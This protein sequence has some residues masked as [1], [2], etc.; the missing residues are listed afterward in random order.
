MSTPNRTPLLGGRPQ[1]TGLGGGMRGPGLAPLPPKKEGRSRWVFWLVLLPL[2]LLGLTYLAGRTVEPV[3]QRL[4]EIP[5]A[6]RLLFGEPVWP[7]LWNKPAAQPVATTPA[8][9]AQSPG[10]TPVVDKLAEEAAKRLAEADLK[11]QEI[12][13][14]EEAVASKEA[15]LKAEEARLAAA[16]QEV[17]DLQ[18]QLQGQLRMEQDRV[19]IVRAMSRTAQV[20]FFTTLTDA[21][22]VT[23]LKYMTTDEVAKILGS[24]DPYRAGR[25]F[26]QLPVV[27]R[28]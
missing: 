17:A 4:V 12:K 23:I 20:Q 13:R 6:G 24:M 18:V 7:I 21:E 28:P 27:V 5:L 25:L 8:P 9:T 26:Y 19:E 15:T 11:E 10:A 3:R 1:P 14:R 2:L 22:A 16:N